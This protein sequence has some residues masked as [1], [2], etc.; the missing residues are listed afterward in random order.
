MWLGTPGSIEY[1]VG[2]DDAGIS[3]ALE[4]AEVERTSAI[5]IGSQMRV[6]LRPH[7]N[8]EIKSANGEVK[9]LG[10]DRRQSWSWQLLPKQATGGHRLEAEVEVLDASGRAIEKFTRRVD[11]NVRV[12]TWQGL[13]NALGNARSL[14]DVLSALF[15]SW[16]SAVVSLTALIA[17]LGGLFAAFRRLTPKGRQRSAARRAKRATKKAERAARPPRPKPAP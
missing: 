9:P 12:G 15:K 8:F 3:E 1:A 6:T 4:G 2:A 14:G 17:A 13:L 5:I 7:W 11:V 10:R 16:D